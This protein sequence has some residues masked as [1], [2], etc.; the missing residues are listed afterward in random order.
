MTRKSLVFAVTFLVFVIRS[1]AVQAQVSFFQ[2]P[3]FSG[4]GTVFVADYNGNGK[5]DILTS[6]GTMNLG[7]GDGTFKLGTPVSVSS[8]QVLAVADFNGDGK[9]D[10]LEQGTG[11]L[12]VMLGKGDGTF[13]APISTASGASLVDVATADLN[14]DGKAD[15]V[16]VFGSALFVYI[17]K[18]DGTFTTGVS[19]NLGTVPPG[20]TLLSLGDFNGDGKTDVLVST[21]GTTVVAGQ[22]IVLLGNGDG[23]FQTTPKISTGVFLWESSAVTGDFNGDGKL[24]LL[25]TG[26]S[27]FCNGGCIGPAAVYI[28]LGNGDGTF[29]APVVC[30]SLSPPGGLINTGLAAAVDLNGDGKLDLVVGYSQ[31]FAEI[32]LGNGDGTFSNTGNYV[33]NLPLVGASPPGAGTAIADFNGDGKLDIAAG[34]SVQLGNGDGTFQGIQIALVPG[35][36]SLSALA[37]GDFHKNGTPDVAV[38]STQDVNGV[39]SYY[40]YILSNDGTGK[41]SLSHTYTLQDSGEVIVTADFNGDGNLDLVVIGQDPITQYWGYSVLLGNGNGSFESPVFYPQNVNGGGTTVVGDFNH[42]G[43]LDLAVLDGQSVAILL[44]NGDGTFAA[45]VQYFDGGGSF[46]VAADFNGDGKLDLATG[47]PPTALLFGNGDGTFQPAVFPANLN[48]F[49][50][51]FTA[52]LNNDGNPDLLSYNQVATGNG[53]GTFSPM[54]ALSTNIDA[55]ADLNSDGKL[56]LLVNIVELIGHSAGGGVQLGNGDGTF[57]AVFRIGSPGNYLLSNLVVDMNGDGR[58]DLIIVPTNGV[59]VVLNTTPPGFA[60]SAGALSPA[61]VTAGSSATST[62]SVKPGSGFTG[63]VTLSCTGLP[64]GASCAFNPPSIANTS[65]TSALTITTSAS[66]AGGTYPVQVLGTAGSIVNSAPLSLVVQGS[67]GFSVSAASGSPTSQI[68]SAGQT[69]TFSLAFAPTG[70]FTGMVNLNCAITPAAT[71]APTCSLSSQ[72]VQINGSGTQTVTVTVGTT[73]PN[74]AVVAPHVTF[75]AGPMPLAWTL[76]FVGSTW[77]WMRNRKR[78]PALAGPLVVLALV[79]S[80]GCGGSG[81][82]STHTSGTPAGTYAVAITA[83]SGNVSHNMTLQVVV[84]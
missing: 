84:Q 32:W 15:V 16:G 6:D 4:S 57:G 5:P 80:V 63:T 64:S 66:V 67:P 1:L 41:L 54:P 56:D 36:G 24:D 48:G 28:V 14:G 22:E 43:K 31:S 18:G 70:S 26:V 2:P 13:Q 12:L 62:V 9:P 69:A 21:P 23:T 77:L 27:G 38:T 37:I 72:S 71:P 17:S 8:G 3:T 49:A 76:I 68:I 74:A 61:T 30:S 65:A 59:A 33:L 78:L 53:D 83:S 47:G 34:D 29:A 20:V 50:P 79:F 11:T 60:L 35:Y 44:G 45:P 39:D 58:P 25:V 81:S 73:A 19:Y 7:N 75:P 51:V 42:D 82:S 55:V 10:V 52:D 46:L 40:V